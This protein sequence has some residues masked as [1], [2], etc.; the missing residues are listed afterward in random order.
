MTMK[1]LVI[2]G[3]TGVIGRTLIPELVDTYQVVILSRRPKKRPIN[4]N[5][6]YEFWDGKSSISHLLEG[7]YGVINLLGESI[8]KKRWTAKQKDKIVASRVD[9]ATAIKQ[10]IEETKV[11]PK[12]WVQASATGYYGPWLREKPYNEYS[13]HDEQTFLGRVCEEWERPIQSLGGAKTRKIIVRTGVVI[14]KDSELVDQ[15]L[16]PLHFKTAVIV[17]T[18]KDR[19]PWIHLQDEVS[20]IRFLLENE[21]SAGIYNLVAPTNITIEEFVKEMRYYKPSWLTY[22]VPRWLL[23]FMFGKE[24]TSELILCNQNV[25]PERLKKEGFKFKYSNIQLAMSEIFVK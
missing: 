12:V 5:V 14:S 1:R 24:M 8:G 4:P 9:S 15:F 20:A 11:K 3:G 13:P 25:Y 17:G 23:N 6:S 2:A 21:N 22:H 10:S 18:G 19:L 16:R 7:V